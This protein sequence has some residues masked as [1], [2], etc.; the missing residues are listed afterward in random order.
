[1]AA[2]R[3]F[4]PGWMPALDNNGDPIPNAR[5]YFYQNKTDI[6]ASVFSDE[7]LSVPLSNPLLANSSGRF[8]AIWASDALTYSYS[9]D[10]A[11]GPAGIPFT[12]DDL[13]VSQGVAIMVAE[14]AE[15]AADDAAASAAAALVSENNSET[16]YQE[17]LAF[18]ATAPEAPSIVNKLNRNGDNADP[19]LLSNI[20]ALDNSLNLSDLSNP[21][22][23]FDNLL[24]SSDAIGFVPSSPNLILEKTPVDLVDML[25]NVQRQDVRDGTPTG[26]Y[27]PYLQSQLDVMIVDRRNGTLPATPTA[28]RLETAVVASLPE[29][30]TSSMVSSFEMIGRG[31]KN[32][33]FVSHVAGGPALTFTHDLAGTAEPGGAGYV[34]S[35]YVEGLMLRG[36]GLRSALGTP[37]DGIKIENA[38]N[39]VIEAIESFGFHGKGLE[40][41]AFA[42]PDI[43]TTSMP[44]IRSCRLQ[45]NDYGLY[46]AAQTSGALAVSQGLIENCWM[47]GNRKDGIY[48]SGFDQLRLLYNAI[49]ANGDNAGANDYGG[50][51]VANFGTTPKN[52]FSMGNEWGNGNRAH[53]LKIDGILSMR[54]FMDR[55]VTNS[56]EF[57][58]PTP[59][60]IIMGDGTSV[61]RNWTIERPQIICH[62]SVAHTFVQV[63]STASA[64]HNSAILDPDLVQWGAAGQIL[65][66]EPSRVTEV[67]LTADEPRS[68]PRPPKVLVVSGPAALNLNEGSIFRVY[69]AGN[70]TIS[71]T[72]GAGGIRP[73]EAFDIFIENQT[74]GDITVTFPANMEPGGFVAPPAGKMVCTRFVYHPLGKF[75]PLS[76]WSPEITM[77]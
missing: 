36:F 55:W 72:G 65:V 44:T 69:A 19:A 73:G 64:V 31:M 9:I 74:V 54:S 39:P 30:G 4:L 60:S 49:Q 25:S 66:N 75:I 6:L 41:T 38:I 45:G 5:A 71:L 58:F 1:M 37:S 7:G 56:A 13:S 3:L 47:L 63:P 35:G 42:D 59:V 52:L 10:A 32:T 43:D 16:A 27:A 57:D 77:A 28:L 14:A 46:I 24:T 51:H 34:T 67:R 21:A 40:I 53:N 70:I 15:A 23:G 50:M 29:R 26:D 2:G 33:V 61:C 76:G 12:G 62:P 8:P 22:L 68:R 20:G 17:I 18:A 48:A 11:Y